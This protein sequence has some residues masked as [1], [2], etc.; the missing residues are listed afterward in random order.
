MESHIDHGGPIP[1]P[2]GYAV[3]PAVRE[4]LEASRVARGVAKKAMENARCNAR[5]AMKLMTRGLSP[6]ELEC[7][8]A[9]R[10]YFRKHPEL[11][12]DEFSDLIYELR[13]ELYRRRMEKV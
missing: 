5:Q 4:A 10:M 11:F 6:L 1:T 2:T 8:V 9:T 7:T 13:R 12:N 3:F